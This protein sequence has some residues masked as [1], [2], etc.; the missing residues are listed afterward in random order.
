MAPPTLLLA[1]FPD[2]ATIEAAPIHDVAAFVLQHAQGLGERFHRSNL[3]NWL[4][5]SYAN[6]ASPGYTHE[7]QRDRARVVVAEAVAWLFTQNLLADDGSP[8]VG[9]AHMVTRLGRSIKTRTDFTSYAKASLLP[10]ELLRGD[11]AEIVV[12]L[13]LAGNYDD[14]VG[15]AFKRLEIM[16][17]KAGNFTDDDYGVPMM[18]EAFKEDGRL[19]DLS[20][21]KSERE[22][23]AHLFAGAMGYFKNPLSHRD[24]GIDDARTAA[25]RILFAN[26]LMALLHLRMQ[27][28]ERLAAAA[29]EPKE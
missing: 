13:F 26:E 17:R 19:K 27:R 3:V 10:R 11:L 2:L 16:V 12:P 29:Q 6:A 20:P 24:V 21:V 15:A 5:D 4:A 28:A 1:A 8:G 14:A 23:F 22:A 25:S 18:R 9:S 7:Q